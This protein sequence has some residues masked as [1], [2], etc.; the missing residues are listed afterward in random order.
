M[1]TT[2][3]DQIKPDPIFEISIRWLSD[4]LPCPTVFRAKHD[5]DHDRPFST[6]GVHSSYVLRQAFGLSRPSATGTCSASL[7]RSFLLLLTCAAGY[8]A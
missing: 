1:F 7:E 4:A 6:F 8:R 2:F 3:A 5:R